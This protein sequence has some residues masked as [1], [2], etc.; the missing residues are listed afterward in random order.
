MEYSAYFFV[1]VGDTGF[2]ANMKGVSG[3]TPIIII[4]SLS[5][6]YGIMTIPCYPNNVKIPP[7]LSKILRNKVAFHHEEMRVDL[8][9][10]ECHCHA[11]GLPILLA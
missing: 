6:T 10:M 1:M 7:K 5:F 9:C 2:N 3:K 4:S 8:S 11:L